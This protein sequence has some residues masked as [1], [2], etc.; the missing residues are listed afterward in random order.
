MSGVNWLLAAIYA[1][2]GEVEG[3][4][5]VLPLAGKEAGST[6]SARSPAIR[7]EG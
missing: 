3:L 6:Q 4:K 7:R 5:R 2:T 1:K